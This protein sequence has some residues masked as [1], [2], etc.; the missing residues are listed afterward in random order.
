MKK[1]TTGL[2]C[3]HHELYIQERKQIQEWKTKSTKCTLQIFL[4]V[5]A[6][7][8]RP[9]VE[10]TGLQEQFGLVEKS[11]AD[12]IFILKQIVEKKPRIYYRNA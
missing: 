1:N 4:K 6:G 3:S 2:V 10:V 5:V 11:C 9:L 12:N 8:L 7:L